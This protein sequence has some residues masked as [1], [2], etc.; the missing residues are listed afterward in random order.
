MKSEDETYSWMDT[1]PSQP[2]N[3]TEWYS[4]HDWSLGDGFA[5]ERGAQ[6]EVVGMSLGG[7]RYYREL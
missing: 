3:S 1:L 2:S 5:Y 4:E 7:V 6:N